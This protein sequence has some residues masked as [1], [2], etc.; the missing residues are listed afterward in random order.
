MSLKDKN[1]PYDNFILLLPFTFLLVLLLRLCQVECSWHH[2][3]RVDKVI[4]RCIFNNAKI[5]IAV[6]D[7]YFAIGI[8]TLVPWQQFPNSTDR[9]FDVPYPIYILVL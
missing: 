7:P 3:S 9:D 8:A 1:I 6:A 2:G 4:T 5:A